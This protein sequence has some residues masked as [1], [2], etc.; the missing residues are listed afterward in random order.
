MMDRTAVKNFAIEARVTLL[1]QVKVRA[2]RFGITVDRIIEP[3]EVSGGLVV[4]GVTLDVVE[5]EQ[6]WQ[7]RRRL[8][9]L[10]NQEKT[11]KGA[12][13]ALID[14]VAYTW[15]NRLAALRFMEVNGYLKRRALSSSDPKLVDPDLLRE[16]SGIAEVEGLPG[17]N[18]SIWLEW[19]ALAEKVPNRDEFLYRRL[20]GLQCV[21]LAVGLPF[22]F[23]E[24]YSAL[25]MPM[26]LLNEDSIVRKL[27]NDIAEVDWRD[28]PDSENGVE[29]V[30]WLYQ[31]YI[32]ERKDEVIGAKKKVEARDIP[33]ATQLFTPHWIVRY[34]VENSLGRLWL[35]AHPE[36]RLRE[37]M[38]YFLESAPDT[39]HPPA[40]SPT[41]GEG[42]QETSLSTPVSS[43]QLEERVQETSLL[44]PAPL[45]PLWEKGL[46]DEGLS[47]LPQTPQELTVIDPACGSGHILVYAFDLL[48][49]IYKEQGYLERD[50]PGLILAH[51]L[52]GLDIDE[53]AVQLASFAV[54]MKARAKNAR[55]LRQPVELKVL[56]VKSTRGF[57][58]AA[59]ELSGVVKLAD[60]QPLLGAFEDA[61]NLGCLM[62]ISYKVR[63]KR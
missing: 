42:G 4:A 3:Q 57:D 44:A 49:E 37:K 52:H 54:L 23:G 19:V 60:W 35:E 5:K 29:I 15:F 1:Q 12:V 43:L 59:L 32:S 38:P 7:L 47:I 55:F 46:G 20:L 34:M 17:F 25:F 28:T 62:R 51:N 41:R 2:E 30:G 50:I 9:D 40:P 26:N 33:A 13:A 45:L 31:F 27:V 21:E 53:R 39:P 61:D 11:L 36:S 8:D 16:A 14:E 48:F 63:L 56:T 10:K 6:Y 24:S 22:L 18:K 58:V